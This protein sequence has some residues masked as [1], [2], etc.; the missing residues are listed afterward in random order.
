MNNTFQVGNL[1]A[2]C[3]GLTVECTG[4]TCVCAFTSASVTFLQRSFASYNFRVKARNQVG[5][6]GYAYSSQQSVGVPS[7]SPSINASVTGIRQ[8]LLNWIR[9]L[10]TGVGVG[11]YQ[12]MTRYVVQRSYGDNTFAGCT[13]GTAASD[14]CAASTVG[15]CCSDVSVGSTTLTKLFVVPSIGPTYFFFRVMGQNEVGLGL[16][17]TP[18][19]EQGVGPPGPI[20]SMKIT[21]V[22]PAQF[23]TSEKYTRYTVVSS[24]SLW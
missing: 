18:A 15:A 6:G 23:H 14:N 19:K 20:G 21:V 10:D 17:P 11:K 13:Y 24:W 2:V 16:E 8:I 7:M 12:E 5:F 1:K 3:D 9:L 4:L 22:G